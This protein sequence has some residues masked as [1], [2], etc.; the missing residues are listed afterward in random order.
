TAPVADDQQV[1]LS[2][3]GGTVSAYSAPQANPGIVT[4]STEPRR[5][6]AEKSPDSKTGGSGVGLTGSIGA[7]ASATGKSTGTIAPVGPLSSARQAG[8]TAAGGIEPRRDW[9]DPS[10]LRLEVAPLQTSDSLF[11]VGVGGKIAALAK[12]LKQGVRYEHMLA[13]GLIV[14]PPGQYDEKAYV[15]SH[16]SN[17]YAVRIPT[18]GIDWRFTTGTPIVYKPA[19]TD[20]DIYI[21]TDRGGLR[22]LDRDS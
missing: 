18:G 8:R 3:S 20:E 1:F 19:V 13:D 9:S 2:L 17:L 10:G 15:A 4:K 5:K 12:G 11:L 22:R 21:T 7:L 14:V 16:D 6:D